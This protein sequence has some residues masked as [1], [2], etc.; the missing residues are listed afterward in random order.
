MI[1]TTSIKNR[2][3][4]I[5]IGISIITSLL[6][7]VL[8]LD[9]SAIVEH[10]A[11][12]S[13]VFESKSD[14]E[15]IVVSFGDSY[16]SGEGID[17]FYDSDLPLEERIKSED[18]LA[19][20]SEKSWPGQI[21][22]NG[23][24]MQKNVNWYFE[25]T[26]GART[27]HIVDTPHKKTAEKITDISFDL[28]NGFEIET[29]TNS[30]TIDPQIKV[31]SELH[32]EGKQIDYITL[33]IGGNDAN[34]TD[35]VMD[36]V[37]Y[38]NVAPDYLEYKISKVWDEF[39]NGDPNDKDYPEQEAV[40]IRD[41]LYNTY[42]AIHESAPEAVI[43][44]A[45]YPT[46]FDQNGCFYFSP[47]ACQIVNKAVIEFNNEIENIVNRCKAEGMK[48]CFVDVEGKFDGK[49]AY[50]HNKD[51]QT[52][53]EIDYI[54]PIMLFSKP[55]DISDFELSSAYS[56][57]PTEHGAKLYAEAVNAK[58][59]SI[60][61]DNGASEWPT[62]AS[63][64]EREVVLVL[65]ASGSMDG[66]P[67]EETKK[68][69]ENFIKTVLKE[70][71]SI[72]IVAYD[73]EAYRIS[74]FCM[75]ETYLLNTLQSVN[76]GNTTNIEAGLKEAYSMLSQSDA[77]KKIIVLMSD[78]E[79]NEGLQGDALVEYA[80]TLKDEGIYI[81]TLGFFGSISNKQA[82][83]SLMERIASDGLH[84]EVD[85]ADDLVFFFGD[86][87]DQI[88]GTR[89]QYIRIACP[90]DVEVKYNGEKLSSK[91]ATESQRT[92]FGTLTFEEN[93][94][95]ADDSA[96]N[97]IKILRLKE[98]V[99]YDIHIEGNG[100]GKMNY[101]IGFMDENGEYSDLRE[102]KN[103]KI[104]K[105]TEIDT[106]AAN[107][108]TTILKVDEDGDGKYDTYYSAKENERGKEANYTFLIF[109]PV[110]ILGLYVI[111]LIIIVIKHKVK[112]YKE[113]YPNGK[114]KAIR[115]RAPVSAPS[116]DAVKNRIT[117][118][119]P[120]TNEATNAPSATNAK[121]TPAPA[122]TQEYNFCKNCGKQKKASAA[123]CPHCGAKS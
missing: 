24:K 92:E 119:I 13:I 41:R 78:G 118:A 25:A 44:V 10:S 8:C 65:D 94:E 93:P 111:I 90:V 87:A 18:W 32:N 42:K 64:D 5:L 88:R 37:L 114:P 23:E 12:K 6:V 122:P 68:A 63:S 33:T 55:Q 15:T 100:K 52:K 4:C 62:M 9:V 79:P 27:Y 17:D 71:A 115:E 97:R 101:T 20:R 74:N 19:H 7:P 51:S 11:T 58:I 109:I 69:S 21:I 121:S 95:A 72:G 60:E 110:G 47:E 96:D 81:Y 86:I 105:K 29:L 50:S 113:K 3:F 85:N 26:S 49:E 77:K 82:A 46:L 1:K 22:A 38:G 40:P 14:D 106:V 61:K 36:T 53:K 99:A 59:A 31:I 2:L 104:T 102:F 67:M 108:S 45:G 84:Y 54:N 39:Y 73:D 28:K 107:T 117:Q 103:I 75:N 48:I 76:P 98:G 83:Q 80:N 120:P 66:P 123:F 16:S 57:H 30:E 56:M 35:I 91:D 89:Y 43:I 116:E 112:V 70:D 34:F